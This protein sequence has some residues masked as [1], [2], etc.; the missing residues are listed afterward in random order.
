MVCRDSLLSDLTGSKLRPALVLADAGRGDWV[1]CQI[2]SRAYAD[3]RAVELVAKNFSKG[4]PKV[5]S[6]ARR[7]KLFTAS[8]GIFLQQAGVLDSVT[9]RKVIGSVIALVCPPQDVP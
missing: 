4:G 7:G 1:L 3:S 2:T 8:A 5:A 9:S 6:F